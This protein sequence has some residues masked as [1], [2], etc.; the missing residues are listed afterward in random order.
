MRT[1]KYQNK[2]KDQDMHTRTHDNDIY[3]YIYLYKQHSCVNTE[4]TKAHQ[5]P[6]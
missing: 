1:K 5:L 4:I 2:R 6:Q 3:I